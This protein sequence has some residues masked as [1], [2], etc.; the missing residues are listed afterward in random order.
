MEETSSALTTSPS[1]PLESDVPRDL[2]EWLA[3]AQA[4]GQIKRITQPVDHDEEMGAITYMAHQEI[5]AP[6]LLFES[7]R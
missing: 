1:V 4:L 7:I 2:R 5:G 3:R 6:A